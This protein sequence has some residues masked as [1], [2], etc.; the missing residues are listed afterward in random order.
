MASKRSGSANSR[1]AVSAS[2]ATRLEPGIPST[3]PNVAM[4]DRVKVSGPSLASTVIVSPSVQPSR[5]AVALSRTIS[6]R[7]GARPSARENGLSRSSAIQLLPMVMPRPLAGLVV[8]SA[9]TSWAK[10]W[11]EPS[12]AATPLVARTVSSAEASIRSRDSPNSPSTAELRRTMASMPWLVVDTRL[13]KVRP[14]VSVRIMVPAMKATPR[15]TA[16]PVSAKRSLWAQRPR[17]VRRNMAAT[18]R[19]AS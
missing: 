5:S 3:S 7:S 19:S 8:P 4:P 15:T 12:A 17:M 13:S 16:R 18:S 9:R 2:V 6:P 1:W 14:I 10:P 11:M